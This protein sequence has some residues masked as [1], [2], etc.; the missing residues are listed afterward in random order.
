VCPLTCPSSSFPQQITW[1]ECAVPPHIEG[2]RSAVVR[3][4]RRS[5]DARMAGLLRSWHQ[6]WTRASETGQCPSGAYLEKDAAR[7]RT[8]EVRRSAAREVGRRRVEV[9]RTALEIA[10]VV[11]LVHATWC[12]RMIWPASRRR[13]WS[14]VIAPLRE[15]RIGASEASF[16]PSFAG[17]HALAERL[18]VRFLGEYNRACVVGPNLSLTS[19]PSS[20]NF[21]PI[22]SESY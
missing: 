17:C 2:S 15:L 8:S 20:A 13:S 12:S 9:G 18:S 19:P 1:Y 22:H 11:E 21:S 10:G 4:P 5:R 3:S 16:C 7:V 14:P 6:R